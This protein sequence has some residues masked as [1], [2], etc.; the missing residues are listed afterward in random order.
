MLRLLLSLDYKILTEYP[1]LGKSYYTLFEILCKNH[2][3]SV[4]EQDVQQFI[5]CVMSLKAGLGFQD[6]MVSSL[7]C[8]ALDC[9]LESFYTSIYQKRNAA[10]SKERREKLQACRDLFPSFFSTFFQMVVLSQCSNQWAVSRVLFSLILLYPSEFETFKHQMVMSQSV[11]QQQTMIDGF[12]VLLNG[13]EL[14]PLLKYKDKFS[15]NL[16]KFCHDLKVKGAEL[17]PMLSAHR[18]ASAMR[19]DVM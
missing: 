2:T 16:N 8:S 5:E 10:L 12:T 13:L 19:Q 7:C 18:G 15:Q 9:L 14:T 3:D 17:A 6:I 4:I 11:D 1:K